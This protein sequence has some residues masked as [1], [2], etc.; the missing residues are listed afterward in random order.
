[1]FLVEQDEE[2]DDK[3]DEEEEQPDRKARADRPEIGK[4]RGGVLADAGVHLFGV[5]AELI[6]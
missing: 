4:E 6:A 1:M 3:T 2:G 5:D